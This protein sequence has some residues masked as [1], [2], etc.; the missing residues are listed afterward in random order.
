MLKAASKAFF[1]HLCVVFSQSENN[2]KQSNFW[3]EIIA[4]ALFFF[5]PFWFWYV[6]SEG[7]FAC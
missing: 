6:L 1:Q 5:L 4:L 3:L 2:H 7:E